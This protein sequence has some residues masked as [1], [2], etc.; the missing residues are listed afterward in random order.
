M[1]NDI[2]T[3]RLAACSRDELRDVAGY[4]FQQY[5]TTARMTKLQR[6]FFFFSVK[7]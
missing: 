2:M 4:T 7:Q 6:F 1:Y 5:S 3:T